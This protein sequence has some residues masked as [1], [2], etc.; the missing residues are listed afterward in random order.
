MTGMAPL[1]SRHP[2][3]DG[4]MLEHPPKE[5]LEYR[6]D[7]SPILT[8]ACLAAI[9]ALGLFMRLHRL[10]AESAWW[11]EFTSLTHL[12]A[13][14]LWKFLMLNRTLDPAT[15]PLYYTLE[16][17]WWHHV[18]AS[19]YSLR[20][21]SILLGLAGVPL[22]YVFGRDLF[23]KRAGLMAALCLAVSP[24]HIHHAQGIRMYVLMT[25]LALFSSWT[26]MRLV[27]S[28]EKRW[29]AAHL[30][31]NLLL[32]WTHPFASLMI[33][34]EA[35]YIIVFC[36]LPV[37]RTAA[38]MGLT[39]L[40]A[41]P[42]VLY[43][44]QVRF[45]SPQTTSSWLKVPQPGEFLSD[46]FFDDVVSF[47]YQLRLS[48]Y[49][50]ANPMRNLFDWAL[51]AA[52]LG[53]CMWVGWT[54]WKRR[55]RDRNAFQI[56]MFLA[57]WL[58]LPAAVLYCASLVWRPC[59]FPR[60]TLH[61]SL[62]LYLIIGGAVQSAQKTWM[63][64]GAAAAMA[65]LIGFQWLALQPGPQRTD[66][67][68]A[69]AQVRAQANPK[70]LVLVKVSIWRDVFRYSLGPSEM[71]IASAESAQTLA[72][73]AGFFLEQCR[74]SGTDKDLVV[75]AVVLK[76]Y[77]DS[78]PDPEFEDALKGLGLAFTRTEFRGI[79]HV[80]VYRVTR[81]GTEPIQWAGRD[82][83]D[84]DEISNAFADLALELTEGRNPRAALEAFRWLFEADPGTRLMYG[85]LQLALVK[86]SG[87]EPATLS[88][89]A[90][91][92]AYQA[93]GRRDFLTAQDWFREALRHD[94]EYALAYRNLAVTALI[95]DND[96]VAALECL[97]N[98]CK[99]D[100]DSNQELRP[101]A[102]FL[103]ARKYQACFDFL[104]QKDVPPEFLDWF[105]RRAETPAAGKTAGA[106]K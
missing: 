104:K 36:P 38:W 39:C 76:P 59:I 57:A 41:V 48:D 20:L 81:A 62:A 88:V 99:L 71:A 14:S 89:R 101:F 56:F 15:L 27:R 31:G 26:F 8:A 33:G 52:L 83:G 92:K 90:L 86:K 102:E 30:L 87:V 6:Q 61:S 10:G 22:L 4:A 5:R 32:L 63:A 25:L 24:I 85:R 18:G 40:V 66:W 2:S 47:A 17:L 79:E 93:L 19:V 29:W 64:V 65:G 91:L 68:S 9:V 74:Q 34:V 45:W 72:S 42:S 98:A 94:P 43:L 3:K 12:G 54:C 77:F 84:K 100:P 67:Q 53:S 103:A 7:L 55:N 78:G 97:R 28:W 58:L 21:L 60:Y 69:A 11:D 35:A 80:L 96:E 106:A 51:A 50:T 37:K 44:S 16:Y 73:Q 23:G 82:G 49:W 1:Q 95:V 75:W 46:L 105:Q 13:P 70:D